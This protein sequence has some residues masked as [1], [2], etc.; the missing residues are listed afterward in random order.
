[1]YENLVKFPEIAP[2]FDAHK[3]LFQRGVD[4]C[5]RR[6]LFL[7]FESNCLKEVTHKE[8]SVEDNG[9][10]LIV[11]GGTC[12]IWRLFPLKRFVGLRL[13]KFHYFLLL[14]AGCCCRR[15]AT[16][17]FGIPKKKN[18]IWPNP[19]TKSYIYILLLLPAAAAVIL[20]F[21]HLTS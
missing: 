11:F 5:F 9:C 17:C 6:F 20:P 12:A 13:C 2:K 19:K 10:G 7:R 16:L 4:L 15:T 3:T 21:Y 18:G 8:E 1:M 14:A